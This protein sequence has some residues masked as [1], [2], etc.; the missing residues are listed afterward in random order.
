MRSSFCSSRQDRNSNRQSNPFCIILA[1]INSIYL[2]TGNFSDDPL[3]FKSK[4]T[5]CI[6]PHQTIFDAE[7]EG[8]DDVNEDGQGAF[9]SHALESQ[10]D[11]KRKRNKEAR[12][13]KKPNKKVKGGSGESEEDTSSKQTRSKTKNTR[14]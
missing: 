3:S 14:K 5:S 7:E 6:V 2:Q 4:L 13:N 12:E 11:G 9:R 1:F 8:D 10:K